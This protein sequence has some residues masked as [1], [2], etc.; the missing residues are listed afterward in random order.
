MRETLSTAIGGA[1]HRGEQFE[2]ITVIRLV[3]S[4]NQMPMIQ[5][6]G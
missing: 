4:T 5:E 2:A 3:L 6:R 1:F